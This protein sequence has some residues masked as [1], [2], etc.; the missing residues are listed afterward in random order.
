VLR[1]LCFIFRFGVTRTKSDLSRVFA[2]EI[3]EAA[4]RG[5][6]TTQ[7]PFGSQV[8]GVN[9]RCT[10]T[11]IQHLFDNAHLLDPSEHFPH[12]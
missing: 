7:L 12:G 3:A 9:W 5:Y 11:G 10:S 6:L 2:T 8:Y 4:S 1:A